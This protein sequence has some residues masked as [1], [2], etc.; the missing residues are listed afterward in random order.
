MLAVPG[1]ITSSGSVG[2]NNLLKTGAVPVTS[3]LDVLHALGLEDR[4]TPRK[5]RG[6]NAHEQAILDLMQQGISEGHEL[7]DGSKLSVSEF[8]QSLTM[9]EIGSKIRPLGANKWGIY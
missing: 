2:T 1:N 4:A 6:R 5:I 3:Y 7:L 8:N 9:L